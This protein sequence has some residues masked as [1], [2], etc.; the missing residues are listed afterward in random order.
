MSI[1]IVEDNPTNGLILK[2]LVKKVYFGEI[3]VEPDPAKALQLC[4]L[5]DFSLLLVDQMLPGMT[6]LQ[7]FRAL[8]RFPSYRHVPAV[9][10][11]A[12]TSREL[13]E[14]ALA[15]GVTEFLTKPVEALGFRSLMATLVPVEFSDTDIEAGI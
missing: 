11:T 4:Q 9:M 1:L 7:F 10:V 13:R 15:A 2:H 8:R 6:G 5:N 14:Q 12:D 3:I